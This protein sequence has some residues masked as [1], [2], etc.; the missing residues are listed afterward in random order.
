MKKLLRL[1]VLLSFFLLHKEAA[2]FSNVTCCCK[3]NG[4]WGLKKFIILK[5]IVFVNGFLKNKQSLKLKKKIITPLHSLE[6][7]KKQISIG[8]ATT[9]KVIMKIRIINNF[10][11]FTNRKYI[12]NTET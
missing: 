10:S 11:M 9:S 4:W 12:M 5:I 3:K 6:K 7:P 8:A 1:V 2:F